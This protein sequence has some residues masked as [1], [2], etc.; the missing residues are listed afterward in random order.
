MD[1]RAPRDAAASARARLRLLAGER[2]EDFEGLLERYA[3][4]GVLRRVADSEWR[5]K[6]I[7]KGAMLFPLWGIDDHRPTRDIDFLGRGDSDPESLERVFRSILGAPR[8][9][10]GLRFA[11]DAIRVE[12]IREEERYGGARVEARATLAGAKM[13]VQ[14][15]VGFGDAVEDVFQ[16]GYPCL[17]DMPAPV[18]LAYSREAAIAEKLHAMVVRG[19]ANSRMKDYHDAYLLSILERFS[20]QALARAVAATFLRRATPVPATKPLGLTVEFAEDAT[21]RAQWKTYARRVHSR[22]GAPE[23][24]VAVERLGAFLWPA[25]E[26]SRLGAPRDASW[27]P[28]RGAWD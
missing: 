15:D 11:T 10:D 22:R 12:P 5:D 16:G 9:V 6:F 7:L 21:K 20:L 3:A 17:L 24:D 13:R 23:L 28:S 25:L 4:E 8:A 14:I 19:M 26:T 2:G 27:D 18:V 1:G